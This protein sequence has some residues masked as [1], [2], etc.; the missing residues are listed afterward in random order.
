M[1][2]RLLT[3]FGMNGGA[4]KPPL[5][6][7]AEPFRQTEPQRDSWWPRQGT[8]SSHHPPRP[9]RGS[10][11]RLCLCQ[12]FRIPSQ[13]PSRGCMCACV[14]VCMCVLHVCVR[15]RALFSFPAFVKVAGEIKG[16]KPQAGHCEVAV[17]V[18]DALRVLCAF[19]STIFK[20]PFQPC[21]PLITALLAAEPG[22]DPRQWSYWRP[23]C[24]ML[25]SCCNVLLI[26]F[27]CYENTT[28]PRQGGK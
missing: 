5:A 28:P 8:H 6:C 21:F 1:S 4:L 18:D 20:T 2:P 17:V 19:V 13:E 23:A 22:G 3:G 14:G 7:C 9:S 12:P 24:S 25:T 15:A 26:L 10:A 27:S 11:G 16:G